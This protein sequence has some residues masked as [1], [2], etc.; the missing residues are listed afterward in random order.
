MNVKLTAA[1]GVSVAM[2]VLVEMIDASRLEAVDPTS[3][4]ALYFGRED[5]A[6]IAALAPG[7]AS[8]ALP[9][10]LAL[11][12]L[13]FMNGQMPR[14]RRIL[15]DVL[16][17]DPLD[18]I[19]IWLAWMEFAAG[20][21]RDSERVL[22][23]MIAT[24]ETESGS[25]RGRLSLGWQ[26]LLAGD[27]RAAAGAFG[28]VGEDPST[29]LLGEAS[30]LLRG[31]ALLLA[32]D[33]DGAEAALRS[34]TAN[35]LLA[36]AARDLAWLRFRRGDVEHARADLEALAAREDEGSS[37]LGVAWVTILKHG[38]RAL[39]RRWQRA[40]R[41]RPRGQDPTV[42]LMNVSNRDAGADAR[43]M[44]QEFFTAENEPFAHDGISTA[45]TRWNGHAEPV[46]ALRPLGSAQ[47]D[48]SRAEHA[49]VRT[50][51]FGNALGVGGL[52]ALLVAVAASRRYRA[53]PHAGQ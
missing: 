53:R 6:A 49:E 15:L 28:R 20:H 12:D 16:Q 45:L 43:D 44:L 31:E 11:A 17:K 13:Y 42:F 29:P 3:G 51:R 25:A 24:A 40:Y 10:R 47:E 34:V 18:D 7:Q 8:A 22:T 48:E 38:P 37:A 32:H 1:R 52:L 46:G 4:I 36:D 26:Y 9:I 21:T 30:R 14:A 27:G 19:A 33:Y 35:S 23:D 5:E 2:L 50:R 41:E 39:G